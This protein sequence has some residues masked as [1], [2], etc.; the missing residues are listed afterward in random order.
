MTED[1]KDRR[2]DRG[3]SRRDLF[4]RAGMAG[5]MAAVSPEVFDRTLGT[6]ADAAADIA[7]LRSPAPARLPLESLTAA[8]A[9]TLEAIGTLAGGLALYGG[10]CVMHLCLLAR[11]V[12]GGA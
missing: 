3:F 5:A 6:V 7:Q 2:T 11:W 9:E 10:V 1:T 12:S 8:E 4:K